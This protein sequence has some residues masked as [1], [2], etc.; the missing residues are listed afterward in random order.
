MVAHSTATPHAP[1]ATGEQVEDTE[2]DRWRR[3]V[4]KGSNAMQLVSSCPFARLCARTRNQ[5]FGA[6]ERE[7]I[8]WLR[9]H[10][11]N[12]DNAAVNPSAPAQR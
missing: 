5:G 3:K 6:R 8:G 4:R 9:A 10:L 11:C 2:K 12:V 1:G 7:E